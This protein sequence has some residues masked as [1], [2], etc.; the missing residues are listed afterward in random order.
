MSER[1]GT[2]RAALGVI[3]AST[4]AM[5][6]A[7]AGALAPGG[8]GAWTAWAFVLGI[9]CMMV[10]LMVLGAARPG[11]GVGRLALPF[12]FVWLVLAG[13]F[14]TVLAMG[15][16]DPADPTLWLGL[17][18]RAAI[19]LYGIGLLPVLVL[20]LAYALTFDALTL[21]EDDL[22][23]VRAA[24]RAMDESAP[25]EPSPLADAAGVGGRA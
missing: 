18:P 6:A 3:V 1:S 12:A 14:A 5:A 21:G 19:V 23:R 7:Y 16:V 8:G 20:P 11:G 17:P 9:A 2:R 4:V 24:R 13:G 15:P 25:R 10:G 22:A